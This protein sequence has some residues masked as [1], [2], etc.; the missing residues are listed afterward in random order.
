MNM[1]SC[2]MWRSLVPV[3]L[4]RSAC[5]LLAQTDVLTQHNNLARTG[6]NLSETTLT[7]R[8][9]A[10]STFGMPFKRAVDDQLYTQPLVVTGVEIAGG[11]HDVVYVTTVNNS[12]YTFD[13]ND[14]EAAAPFWY[15]N[16]GTPANLYDANFG[17]RDINGNMGIIGAPVINAQKTA[18]YVVALTRVAGKFEQRLHG[19]DLASSADLPSSPVTI[20]APDFDPLMQNQRP[21][22]ALDRDD[23]YIGYASHCDKLL[24]HG[25]LFSYDAATLKQQ[26]VFNASPGGD[27]ASIWQ[28]GQAPTIDVAGNVYVI[29]GNGSWDGVQQFSESFL[30]LSPALTLLDWFTPINHFELSRYA[31]R[32]GT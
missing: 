7:P 13:A 16:F 19:L 26:A 24:Y 10:G 5:P 25:F 12:V 20:R 11:K 8:D 27:A 23:L 31:C 1:L 30:K 17:C 6:A 32:P 4:L 2:W 29:T 21:A 18:L 15:V 14:R 3:L 22:L 9:V 28:S